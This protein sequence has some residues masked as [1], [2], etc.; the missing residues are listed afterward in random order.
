[1]P[2]GFQGQL[3]GHLTRSTTRVNQQEA[4]LGTDSSAGT[5]FPEHQKESQQTPPSSLG[6]DLP[7]SVWP[8]LPCLRFP[9]FTPCPE[10]QG[11]GSCPVPEPPPC[12]HL[13]FHQP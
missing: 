1:M 2:P 10:L 9:L 12:H 7:S 4:E 5:R 6:M 8:F 3:A 13:H 11:T